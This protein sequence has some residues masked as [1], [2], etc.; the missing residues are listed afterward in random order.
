MTG[1]SLVAAVRLMEMVAVRRWPPQG[2]INPI[3]PCM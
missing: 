1:A 2:V 3:R